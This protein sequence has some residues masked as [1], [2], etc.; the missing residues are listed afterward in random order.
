VQTVALA[1]IVASEGRSGDFDRRFAPL[2]NHLAE[3][4]LGIAVAWM[5]AQPLPPVHLIEL[6]GRLVVRDG[7][8]RLSVARALGA[9]EIEA[10]VE[11]W[12]LSPRPLGGSAAECVCAQA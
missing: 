10:F 6:D 8:H 1:Q 12:E 2:R 9:E 4:W 5:S 3:R 7:H 11:R